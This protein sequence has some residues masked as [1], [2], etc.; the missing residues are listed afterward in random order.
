MGWVGSW[1]FSWAINNVRKSLYD[2]LFATP[3]VEAGLAAAEAD[4]GEIGA[5]VIAGTFS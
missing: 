4:E 1:F 2:N 5:T 3:D